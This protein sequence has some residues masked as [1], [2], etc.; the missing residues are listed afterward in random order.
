[1]VKVVLIPYDYWRGGFL[2]QIADGISTEYHVIRPP[3]ENIGNIHKI[4]ERLGIAPSYIKRHKEKVLLKLYQRI[5]TQ[6]HVDIFFSISG[7]GLSLELLDFIKV[8]VTHMIS[9]VADDPFNPSPHRDQN[10]PLALLRYD[11]FLVAEHSWIRNINSVTSG[12]TYYYPGGYNPEIWS[13]DK[14]VYEKA[15]QSEILFTGA[16]YNLNAEGLFR[17][18]I[19]HHLRKYDIKIWGDGGWL[20][21]VE[22]NFS[23]NGVFQGSRLEFKDLFN[24]LRSTKIYLNLPSPQI[25]SDFQPRVFELGAAGIF[26]ICTY[27]KSLERLFGDSIV[28]FRDIN[29]LQE[30]VKF[31]LNDSESRFRKVNELR[32]K[33]VEGNFTWG[34]SVIS[35]L[36]DL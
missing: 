16:S 20:K 19:A 34:G 10:Y 26:Q 35:F 5:L 6:N 30:L 11:M 33:I 7:G 28:M 23:M 8:N 18:I 17:G 25:S 31:Y 32:D 12:R 4:V 27:S 15:Y 13:L 14:G 22:P 29:E 21:K 3:K 9:Y 24:A 36:D 2:N 1:M